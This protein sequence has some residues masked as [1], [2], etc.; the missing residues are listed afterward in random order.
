MKYP[1]RCILIAALAFLAGCTQYRLEGVWK[2]TEITTL[3]QENEA[4]FDLLS[5]WNQGVVVE[6]RGEE[7][8]L[9]ATLADITFEYQVKEDKVWLTP[10]NTTV[11]GIEIRSKRDAGA[12]IGLPFRFE[13]GLL[14][15]GD[16]ETGSEIVL[17]RM[18]DEEQEAYKEKADQ[19]EE[20]EDRKAEREKRREER[21]KEREEKNSE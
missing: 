16:E 13:D 18:S 4:T 8:I 15:L 12:E 19:R 17:E 14:V 5:G 2:I 11:A 1:L 6:F 10:K 7:A 9:H 3:N 21:R 20:K